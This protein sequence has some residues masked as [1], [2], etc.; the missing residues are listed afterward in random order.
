MAVMDC[1][2]GEIVG[3][4]MDDTMRNELYIKSFESACKAQSAYGMVFHSDRGS[5]FTGFRASLAKYGAV[6]SMS[7]TGC[8]YDNARMESFFTTL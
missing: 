5:Q 7:D 1:C 4:A 6:Q 2:G 8:C 3:L